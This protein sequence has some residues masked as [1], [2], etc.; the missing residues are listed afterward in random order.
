MWSSWW[1]SSRPDV[2]MDDSGHRENGRQRPDQYKS[3]HTQWMMPQHQMKEHHT[4]K[5]IALMTER[6]TAIQERNLAI[7][8]K[9]AALAERDMAIMQRDTAI[10][11]RDSAIIE[12]D[13]AIAALELAR[14]SGMNGNAK[15]LHNHHHNHQHHNN[16][17]V[18]QPSPPQL[19]DAP[20]DHVREMHIMEAYP[21]SAALENDMKARKPKQNR[22]ES[23]AQAAPSPSMK[24]SSKRKSKRVGVDDLNSSQVTIAKTHH[25]G[26][27]GV[28]KKNEWKDQDLGLN[29]VTFDESTMPVPVCSCTGKF[30]PCYK[31]GNG[32]WQSSCCTTT[33]S[34]YPLPVMANKRHARMG[35]RKMSGSAFSKLLSRVAAEGHDLSM[36]VD[37][38]DHWAKHGTNRYITIK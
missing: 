3:V 10:A 28:K 33:L 13:D 32:G 37:L 6:D 4:M 20:Y 2:D 9:K 38:K 31:W 27:G 1:S 30:R 24:S 15:N 21:I 34:M 14:E 12:R 18:V 19:S 36:P 11:E 5:L 23:K 29:Q 22:K 26:G 8:E 16:L 25:N 17:S 35:G 7:S